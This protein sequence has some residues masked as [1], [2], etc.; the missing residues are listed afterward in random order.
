LPFESWSVKYSSLFISTEP[1]SFYSPSGRGMPH[2][3][4]LPAIRNQSLFELIRRQSL[5]Q[6]N[7]RRRGRGLH[8]RRGCARSG[9]GSSSSSSMGAFGI[10][11]GGPPPAD[12][13]AL[14]ACP[15][16]AKQKGYAGAAC[17]LPSDE[18]RRYATAPPQAPPA[19]GGR[20]PGDQES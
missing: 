7:P 4:V 11:A 18:D 16:M 19:E 15:R 2:L 10:G 17:A 3:S 6:H 9:P 20:T 13:C 5:V 14:P 8:F 12:N 1:F